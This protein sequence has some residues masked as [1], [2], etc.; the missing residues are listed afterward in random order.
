MK[1]FISTA[2]AAVTLMATLVSCGNNGGAN[3]E[4]SGNDASAAITGE[5][6]VIT[7]EEGSGTRDAFVELLEITDADGNDAIYDG[8]EITEK[9]SVMLTSVAGNKKAIGYVSL[10]S[11]SD[12]VKAIKV[13]GVE[14]TADNV[15]SGEYTV[16]RNFN[17]A[18]KEDSLSDVAADFLKFVLS[19]EGQAII[20]EEGYIAVDATEHYTASGVSGKF[21]LAGSTSVGPVAEVLCEAYKELNPDVQFDVQQT[22]SSAGMTS[23]SEGACDIGMASRDLKDSEKEV[24][25]GVKIATDGIAVVVNLEN[26]VES[27]TSEQIANIFKGELTDWSEIG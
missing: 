23:A 19:V 9:T 8:A 13:N 10:G 20:E 5:I 26:S 2:L 15:K 17:L 1:K 27:L 16:S 22:G 11:L 24:L 7:R 25:T 21:T 4:T 6:T 18:Y 3:T 12:D 14:A